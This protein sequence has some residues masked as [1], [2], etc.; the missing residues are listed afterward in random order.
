MDLELHQNFYLVNSVLFYCFSGKPNMKTLKLVILSLSLVPFARLQGEPR[1]GQR[2]N[3][4]ERTTSVIDL[5]TASGAVTLD[6]RGTCLLLE[7]RGVATVERK[8]DHIEVD[9]EFDNVQD[10]TRFGPEYLTFVIWG[11]SPEGRSTNLGE[12]IPNGTKSRF[13][14][15]SEL[16]ALGLIVTAEPYFAVSQPSDRVVIESVVQPDTL[17]QIERTEAKYELLPRGTYTLNAPTPPKAIVMDESTPLDLYEARNAV[18]IAAWSYADNEAA[19]SL[20]KAQ[21]LLQSAEAYHAS[22]AGAETVSL[23]AREAVRAAENARLLALNRKSEDSVAQAPTELSEGV[24]PVSSRPDGCE[25][26]ET[27][28]SPE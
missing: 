18:W 26:L 5:G 6:F 23:H 13:N 16:H 15:T 9:G 28:K 20:R 7:A 4:V 1:A 10:A 14:V 24:S 2:V 12:V 11:I 19:E 17:G 27:K 25:R 22:R 21:R 8:G 3:V